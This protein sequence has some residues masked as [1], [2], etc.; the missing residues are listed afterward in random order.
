LIFVVPRDD[1]ADVNTSLRRVLIF[2]AAFI[3]I[4]VLALG[5][6]AYFVQQEFRQLAEQQVLENANL[7]METAKA[8]RVYTTEQIEPVLTHEEARVAQGVKDLNDVLN[9]QIPQALQQAVS[10]LPNPRERQ[11]LQILSEQIVQNV[12]QQPRSVPEP[13]FAAQSIPFYAATEAFNYF[14]KRYPDYSYKEAALN[15]TNPRDRTAEWEADIVNI[16]NKTPTKTDLV[17]Y[18]ETPEGP[19]LY[20]SAPIRVDSQSCLSCHSS[21]E[22]APREMTKVYGKNNG[23][24][25]KINDIIGAQIVSVP[26][27]LVNQSA[28]AAVKRILCWLAGGYALV[29]VTV[30]LGVYFLAR[31]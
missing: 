30:N 29:F 9:T 5:V 8:S 12:K 23:F 16:F 14:R 15:P 25:W 31:R 1:H 26:A 28:D 4:L 3:P 2:N 21:A 13:E 18:R 19:S 11:T 27:R 20:Y 10:G 24:G 6:T 7:M 17:G 22:D